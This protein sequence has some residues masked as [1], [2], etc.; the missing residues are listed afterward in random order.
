VQFGKKKLGSCSE[1]DFTTRLRKDVVFRLKLVW[2][3]K[4][5]LNGILLAGTLSFLNTS[6]FLK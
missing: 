1:K 3:R 2:L 6:A 4:G 5:V